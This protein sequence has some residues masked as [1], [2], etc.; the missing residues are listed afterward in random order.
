MSKRFM[1]VVFASLVFLL[2][3]HDTSA[4]YYA[5]KI[6]VDYVPSAVTP[7]VR[8]IVKARWNYRGIILVSGDDV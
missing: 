7:V 1:L 5:D 8:P 3:R 2:S 4:A 6:D